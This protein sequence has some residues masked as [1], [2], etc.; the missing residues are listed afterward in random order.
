MRRIFFVVAPSMAATR[1]RRSGAA[2]I[3]KGVSGFR[4]LAP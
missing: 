3:L 4:G 2:R 1:S